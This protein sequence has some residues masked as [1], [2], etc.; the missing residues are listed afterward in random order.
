MAR[1]AP[2]TINICEELGGAPR[3]VELLK[4]VMRDM[5][6]GSEQGRYHTP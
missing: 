1:M 2:Q 4:D 6:E 5:Y 3:S